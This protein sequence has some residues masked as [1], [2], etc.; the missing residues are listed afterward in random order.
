MKLSTFAAI[1]IGSIA[2]LGCA[3][4]ALAQ[5]KPAPA[6]SKPAAA[7]AAPAPAPVITVNVPGVCVLSREALIGSSTVGKYIS[8]R[9]TQL[10]TQVNAELGGEQNTLQADAK[11]L[12]ATR[13][14][15]QPAQLQ[16]QGQ[17]LQQRASA[18]QE[19][20]QQRDRELQATEQKAIA[21]VLQ[22]ASPLVGDVVKSRA[23][24]LVLDANSVLAG[25]PAM[26]ITPTVVQALNGKFTQFDFEREHLDAQAGAPQA[27]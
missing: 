5:P 6:A 14:T 2:A 25:N 9:M 24:G 8:T 22:E 19:K 1:G 15:L 27:R 4:G 26:D 16:T 20:A 10:S 18:L 12:D 23:C 21:R 11:K 7:A 3:A 17:A 13:A